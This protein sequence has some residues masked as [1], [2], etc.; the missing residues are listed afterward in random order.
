[1]NELGKVAFIYIPLQKEAFGQPPM[2]STNTYG[3]STMLM[4]GVNAGDRQFLDSQADEIPALSEFTVW[5]G[6]WGKI[7]A[8]YKALD[9]LEWVW[10]FNMPQN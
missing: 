4:P 2:C 3:A 10:K 6:D 8:A 5:L 7:Q 1:M 9:P